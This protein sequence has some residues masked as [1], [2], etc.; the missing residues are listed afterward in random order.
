[1]FFGKQQTVNALDEIIHITEAS[2]LR[3]IPEYRYAVFAHRGSMETLGQ[4]YQN[5]YK[6]WMPEAGLKPVEDGL[7]MEVYTEEFDAFSEKSVFYIYV[8]VQ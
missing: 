4:T 5:I 8:P 2:C 7:D 1:V 3:A 6:V